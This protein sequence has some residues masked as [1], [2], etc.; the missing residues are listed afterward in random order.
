MKQESEPKLSHSTA[1]LCYVM[2]YVS[3]SNVYDAFPLLRIQDFLNHVETHASSRS[4]RVQL[5]VP[6]LRSLQK[7]LFSVPAPLFK[8]PLESLP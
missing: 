8:D 5:A 4:L 2:S 7:E 6:V 3:L 1:Y